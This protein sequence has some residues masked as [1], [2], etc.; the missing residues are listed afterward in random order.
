MFVGVFTILTGIALVQG[1]VVAVY[2]T[3]RLVNQY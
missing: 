2:V 1:I 3:R